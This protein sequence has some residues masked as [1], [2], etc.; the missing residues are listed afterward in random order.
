MN[1]AALSFVQE[2]AD[3]G[4]DANDLEGQL[5]IIAAAKLEIGSG[6]LVSTHEFYSVI[7][8]SLVEIQ[9]ALHPHDT[10]GAHLWHA[11]LNEREYHRSPQKSLWRTARE[12][13]MEE[14][15]AINLFKLVL[16]S[17]VDKSK[18]TIFPTLWVQLIKFNAARMFQKLNPRWCVQA[19]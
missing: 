5:L 12:L 2:A 6:E 17:S 8:G 18:Y 15:K 13:K 4:V 9:Q 10:S 19:G 1:V 14:Y 16:E 3:D 7:N 11:P